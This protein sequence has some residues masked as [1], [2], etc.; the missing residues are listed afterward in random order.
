MLTREELAVLLGFVEGELEQWAQ[1]DSGEEEQYGQLRGYDQLK[2]Q[3]RKKIQKAAQYYL[4]KIKDSGNGGRS[5]RADR[6]SAA[7]REID[8]CGLKKVRTTDPESRFMRS[9]KGKVELSYNPQVTVERNGFVLANDVSQDSFDTEQLM[10]VTM[11][12]KISNFSQ[13]GRSMAI[14][15]VRRRKRRRHRIRRALP[16]MQQRTSIGVLKTRG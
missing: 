6:L 8:A 3:N 12:V 1:Q 5:E 2:E 13:T 14:C 15:I 16:M 9:K 7:K 11:R 4:E 10:P